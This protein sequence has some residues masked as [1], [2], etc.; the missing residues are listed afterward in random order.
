MRLKDK[1]ILITG[2]AGGIGE[3][4]AKLFYQEGARLVLSDVDRK[5]GKELAQQYPGSSF[6]AADISD[7]SQVEELFNHT[8]LY[9]GGLDGLFHTAG[10]VSSYDLMSCTEEHFD[11]IMRIHLKGAF[12]CL[13]KAA[14]AMME[15]GGSIVLTSSQRGILGA[16]GSLAYN[17]AKGGIVIM[18]KSAAME[19]GR[20]NIRVNVLCPGATDTP[21]L[22][23]D[24]ANSV[25]PEKLEQRMISAYPLGRFGKAEEAAYGA[26]YLISDEAAFTTGT[27][28]VIDG[29]NT[30]G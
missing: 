11:K 13:Q 24:I 16:T 17:A 5:R 4:A 15:S 27:T 8:R 26:L 7:S 28:L 25:N 14:G 3:A 22:R 19:L 18:G 12:L 30:A 1:R 10:I 9:L 21:M 20:Y 2:A 6:V 29:G 23:A